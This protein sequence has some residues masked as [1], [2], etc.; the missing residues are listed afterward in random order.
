MEEDEE[1]QIS[2]IDLDDENTVTP[3]NFLKMYEE[4]FIYQMKEISGKLQTIE[5]LPENIDNV[6]YI[7]ILLI[8]DGF[9]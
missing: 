3:S 4:G 5:L 7:K 9:Q 6:D 2:E 8:I 1:I